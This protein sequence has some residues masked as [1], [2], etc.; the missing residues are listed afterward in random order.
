T[1][2]SRCSSWRRWMAS[3]RRS[4]RSGCCAP[5][6]AGGGQMVKVQDSEGGASHAGPESCVAAREGRGQAV[7]G[8]GAG[9]VLSREI[10]SLV[11]EHED[12]RDADAITTG[13][14]QHRARR[15][16]E[17][18]ADP[19]RS[20]TLCTRRRTSHGSREVSRPPRWCHRGR[21]G[22]PKG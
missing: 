7:A 8:E 1:A 22:K 4:P 11:L 6:K 21:I 13:G 9:R 15:H 18:S 14:R 19:A 10:F 20:K 12:L 2:S 17:T 3:S 16:G 5:V